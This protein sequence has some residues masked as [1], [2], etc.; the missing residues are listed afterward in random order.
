MG[1]TTSVLNQVR[2]DKASFNDHSPHLYWPSLWGNAKPAID[3]NAWLAKIRQQKDR[4][5]SAR[6]A[7][8]DYEYDDE[9]RYDVDN[10]DEEGGV[11][12]SGNS[13]DWNDN[14]EAL[15]DDAAKYGIDSKLAD[16]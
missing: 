6:H 5:Q 4:L 7:R 2:Y 12:D 10:T 8:Y 1:A 9:D 13:E 16:Q 15:Y 11:Y 3:G 14:D